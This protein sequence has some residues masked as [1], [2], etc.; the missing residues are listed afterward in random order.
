MVRQCMA[1]MAR[2]F[3]LGRMV[4]DRFDPA[5]IK[6]AIMMDIKRTHEDADGEF[7]VS[8]IFLTMSV[9]LALNPCLMV[10]TSSLGFT[11]RV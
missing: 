10:I 7:W 4:L 1:D 2:F 8:R 3:G 11:M 9:R 5:R 6:D